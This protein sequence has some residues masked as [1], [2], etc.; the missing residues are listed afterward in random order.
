MEPRSGCDQPS[1]A[2]CGKRVLQNAERERDEVAFVRR[3]QSIHTAHMKER[4]VPRRS[5]RNECNSPHATA[6]TIARLSHSSCYRSIHL[7]EVVSCVG[8]SQR[9][10]DLSSLRFSPTFHQP[11]GGVLGTRESGNV[12]DTLSDTQK[13]TK[14]GVLTT[15][16]PSAMRPSWS[17]ASSAS[18]RRC[19]G[20]CP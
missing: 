9:Q 16:R 3:H 5:A 19:F 11:L 17:K 13:S 8:A 6:G 15:F 18:S 1:C 4:Y 2:Q 12:L 20:Q 10:T 14:S 7:T